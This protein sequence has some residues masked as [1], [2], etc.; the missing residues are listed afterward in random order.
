MT[1]LT[2]QPMQDAVVYDDTVAI[3]TFPAFVMMLEGSSAVTEEGLASLSANTVEHRLAACTEIDNRAKAGFDVVSTVSTSTLADNGLFILITVTV[4]MKK[5]DDGSE[6]AAALQKVYA[7][8]SR[9][10]SQV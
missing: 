8:R 2:E 3:I 4:T 7:Q 1:K 5:R 10:A 9:I 6:F